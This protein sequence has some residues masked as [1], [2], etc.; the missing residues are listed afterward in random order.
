MYNCTHTYIYII[1]NML[2]IY[3]N[4]NRICIGKDND[5]NKIKAIKSYY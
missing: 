1:R 3:Y 4:K 5:W 2:S